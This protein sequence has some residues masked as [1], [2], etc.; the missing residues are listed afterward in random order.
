MRASLTGLVRPV[1]ALAAILSVSCNDT[2][3]P[4]G[5][6]GGTMGVTVATTGVD[7]D[8]DGYTLTFAGTSRPIGNNASVVVSDLRPGD[9]SVVLDGVDPNC[10]VTGNNQLVTVAATLTTSVSFAV[11]CVLRTGSVRV[12]TVTTGAELDAD[13]YTIAVD[14]GAERPIATNATSTVDGLL[15]GN[16]L[17]ELRGVAKNCVLMEVSPRP[18]VVAFG[19]RTTDISFHVTCLGT[20]KFEV[21]VTTTGV[22]LY[23][24]GFAI[25][26]NRSGFSAVKDVTT[27]GSVTFSEL[28]EGVYTV[29]LSGIVANCDV[30]GSNPRT[31]TVA[32]DVAT[33]IEFDVACASLTRLAFAKITDGNTDIWSISADGTGATRLTTDANLDAE[34]TWSRDGSKIAFTSNRNGNLEI[35]VMSAD[36]SGV[37][38]LRQ[39]SS[40]RPSWSPDG[41]KIAFASHRDGPGEIYVMN[42]DGSGVVQLTSNNV[43]DEQPAWSPDGQRIAFVSSRDGNNEIYVMNADGSAVKRLTSNTIDDSQPAWSPDGSR[44]AIRRFSSCD[45]YSGCQGAIYVMS[46]DGSAPR[47]LTSSSGDQGE[48]TWSP[49]GRK[50]AFSLFTCD[51]YC[52]ETSSSLMVVNV[53][54]TNLVE[55]T[56]GSVF[57]PAWRW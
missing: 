23:P 48:P 21:T 1:C 37:T 46:A 41:S 35:Y 5:G 22:N 30:A 36:G 34:P 32:A 11:V 3:G 52:Y 54:G 49:D 39:N 28:L 29:A 12:A 51:Y 44:L 19:G 40:S 38:R 13:G 15:G 6:G 57:N 18:V 16:H 2:S 50:I 17:V 8:T 24:N 45:Y 56:S 33:V 27:N 14:G 25:T 47:Q 53:D 10:S 20:G 55:L 42:A 9:Y 43:E 7:V 31:A 4:G 26:V